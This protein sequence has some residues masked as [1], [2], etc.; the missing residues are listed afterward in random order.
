MA[1]QCVAVTAAPNLKERNKNLRN[2]NQGIASLMRA[3][4]RSEGTFLGGRAVVA[5]MEKQ[6]TPTTLSSTHGG[7]GNTKR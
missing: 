4:R 2:G 6:L 1:R 7:N 5:H 3:I